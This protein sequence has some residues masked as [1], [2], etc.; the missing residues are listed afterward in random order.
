MTAVFVD[1]VFKFF[2]FKLYLLIK[3][4]E[5]ITVKAVSKNQGNSV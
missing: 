3:E 5:K 1:P 2:I 4:S